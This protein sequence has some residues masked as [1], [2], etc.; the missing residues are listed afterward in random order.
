MQQLKG[1]RRVALRPGEA[2]EV[3]FTLRREDLL[4]VGTAGDRTFRARDSATGAVLWEHKLDAG[5]EGVPAVYEVGGRQ[6][7]T[8]AVGGDGLFA[9]RGNPAPGPSRSAARHPSAEPGNASA[10]V[11]RSASLRTDSTLS[12]PRTQGGRALT[13][14][15]TAT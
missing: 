14:A 1:F 10:I 13:C 5:T 2:K 11:S 9:Q 15:R 7:V 4:F 6:Y 12:A 8:L 3:R